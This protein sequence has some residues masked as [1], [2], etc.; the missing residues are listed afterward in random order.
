MQTTANATFVVSP[1]SRRRNR[2]TD[3][4]Q[5]DSDHAEADEQRRVMDEEWTSDGAMR[6]LGVRSIREGRIGRG[7]TAF[8]AS[9]AIR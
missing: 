9:T 4:R 5:A 7:I 6:M 1:P 3:D 8:A 2:E